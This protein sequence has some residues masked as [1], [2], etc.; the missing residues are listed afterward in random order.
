[1]LPPV[2]FRLGIQI[3]FATQPSRVDAIVAHNC[4]DCCWLCLRERK[5]TTTERTT[6]LLRGVDTDTPYQALA[7]I[8]SLEEQ[9][10]EPVVDGLLQILLASEIAFGGQN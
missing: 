4:S 9:R 5:A 2:R 8:E 10:S 1:M 6:P 3:P 7:R